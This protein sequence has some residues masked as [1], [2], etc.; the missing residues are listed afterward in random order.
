MQNFSD[1]LESLRGSLT[2][3]Q[4][5][6]K[7]GVPL[8]TYTNWIRSVNVPKSD[9]LEKVCTVFGVSADWLLGLGKKET[10]PSGDMYLREPTSKTPM[11]CQGCASKD[12]EIEQLKG[13]VARLERV[14]DK[15]TK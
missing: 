9:Q 8:N 15:L 3:K 12:K 10:I 14:V 2:Q 13:Q 11:E 5:A 7:I 6:S 1:R 4:M